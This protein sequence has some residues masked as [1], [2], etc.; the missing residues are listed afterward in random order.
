MRSDH[1]T[2]VV[3]DSSAKAGLLATAFVVAQFLALTLW[4]APAEFRVLPLVLLLTGTVCAPIMA[5]RMFASTTGSLAR[6][7]VFVYAAL[8]VAGLLTVLLW[9]LTFLRQGF[10]GF[11]NPEGWGAAMAIV[12]AATAITWVVATR[13]T[14]HASWRAAAWTALPILTV[15]GAVMLVAFFVMLS[16]AV[17][18]AVG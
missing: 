11:G 1:L 8:G 10:T 12:A 9:T 17:R 2:N 18:L 3:S 6:A 14:L 16:I 13:M 15:L 7:L 4:D 5:K